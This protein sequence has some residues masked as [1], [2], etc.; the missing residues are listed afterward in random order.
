M[1]FICVGSR[2]YQFDRLLK[3][4]DELVNEKK[5]SE[6]IF[7]Q[8]GKSNYIPKH[9]QYVCYMSPTDFHQ[10]LSDADL[11]ISHGGTGALV[12]ALK[13]G[14]KVIAVPRLAKYEEH[15][16]DHQVQ[17]CNMLEKMQYLKVVYDMSELHDAIKQ[18][19][20]LKTVKRYSHPSNII[21]IIDEY[22]AVTKK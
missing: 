10:K 13:L 1:I 15:I 22:I 5:L 7:A 16:D 12:N 4:I 11:I 20:N 19:K 9:Y 14:K 18:V 8:I 3:K 21:S 6:K 17:I 2:K